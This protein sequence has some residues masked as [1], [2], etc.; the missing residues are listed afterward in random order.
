VVSVLK[1]R[2][3]A[4]QLADGTAAIVTIH[5]S[6]LLRIRDE[7]DRTREQ[8][9]FVV[10]FSPGA[11]LADTTMQEMLLSIIQIRVHAFGNGRSGRKFRQ[12]C[13]TP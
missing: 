10:M 12:R 13:A 5:P 9:S 3:Q 6:F 8:R 7:P 11:R 4:R 2:G 1:T